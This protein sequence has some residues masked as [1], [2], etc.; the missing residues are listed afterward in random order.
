[1]SAAVTIESLDAPRIVPLPRRR[2][3][4]YRHYSVGVINTRAGWTFK[5]LQHYSRL[6]ASHLCALERDLKWLKH[7]RALQRQ[8]GVEKAAEAAFRES[9]IHPET[10]TAIEAVLAKA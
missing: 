7:L 3:Q 1:M 5:S 2:R 4:L 10:L 8:L 9:I 6:R